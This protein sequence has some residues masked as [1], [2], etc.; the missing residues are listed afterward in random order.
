MMMMKVTNIY[1]HEKMILV[2]KSNCFAYKNCGYSIKWNCYMKKKGFWNTYFF[3]SLMFLKSI[4]IDYFQLL[5]IFYSLY[6]KNFV[7][8]DIAYDFLL[9]CSLK[10]FREIKYCVDKIFY[11]FVLKIFWKKK[12]EIKYCLQSST[13]FCSDK[14]YVKSNTVVAKKRKMTSLVTLLIKSFYVSWPPLYCLNSF[15]FL[16]W[17]YSMTS[18][19]A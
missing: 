7:K 14:N 6:W 11:F 1:K 12:R 13:Y 10:R 8:S 19:I 15:T 17:K 16:L 2:L 3:L 4:C 9:L 18:D 5:K